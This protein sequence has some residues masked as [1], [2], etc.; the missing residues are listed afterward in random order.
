MSPVMGPPECPRV[1]GSARVRSPLRASQVFPASVVRQSRF[2]DVYSVLG[3]RG[4]KMMGNVHC[5]RSTMYMIRSRM[6]VE[7]VLLK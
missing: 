1:L 6:K 7:L 2:D 5:H 3:S 4:E